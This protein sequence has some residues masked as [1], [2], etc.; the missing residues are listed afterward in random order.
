MTYSALEVK[1]C[2]AHHL[3]VSDGPWSLVGADSSS[4]DVKVSGGGL[5][6]PEYPGYP[7]PLNAGDCVLGWITFDVPKSEHIVAA[8]YAPSLG[9]GPMRYAE[10]ELPSLAASPPAAVTATASP[11][12]AAPSTRAATPRLYPPG[13]PKVV[14]VSRLPEQVRTLYHEFAGAV[15]VAPGVWT[16]LPPGASTEDALTAEVFD[17]FCVSINAYSRKYQHGKD[18]AGTC[19]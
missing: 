9:H 17:G 7:D 2:A 12:A 11:P 5:K 4:N 19:W 3:S 6:E 18:L 15:A 16:A 13:F 1:V 8:K 14:P 10:W